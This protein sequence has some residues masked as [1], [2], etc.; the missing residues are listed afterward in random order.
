MSEPWVC[1]EDA[2]LLAV[3][4]P[5]GVTT[6]RADDR[7][8]DGMFDWVRRLRPDVRLSILHRLDKATSGVLLFGKSPEA[9][10]ALS[11]QFEERR[12][13][14][15]YELLVARDDRRPAEL[16]CDDPVDSGGTA[17]SAT[18]DFRLAG[19]GPAVQRFDAHPH[20]GRT[21]QVRVHA[22]SLGM[23][24]LG[25]ADHGGAPGPRLCLHAAGLGI[26]HPDGRSL[27][28]SAARPPSFD[29]LLAG[30]EPSAAQLAAR[31]AVEARS[32]LFDPIDTD[33][34]LCIDR[35]H[36]GFPD[37]RVERLG[38]VAFVVDHRDDASPLP[39]PWI[40][41]WSEALD[42][43]AVYVQRRPGNGEDARLV[44]GSPH[45]QIEVRELGLRYL[46]DLR[47]SATSTGL[48]LDQRETRRE[49]LAAPLAGASVLNVFAH[50]G[51]LS[52][53]AAVAGATTVS[54]D[55]S[56]RYLQWA[57]DNLRLN[58]LDPDEH[59]TIY[60][61]ALDWMGRLAKKGRTFDVVL[62][63][64]PSTSTTRRG[65]QRWSVARDLHALVAQAARLC[66]PG[67]R[68]YVSTNMRRLGWARF[69][70]QIDQGVSAAGRAAAVD[71][72]TL[73]LDHRSGS[74]DPPYLK[75]AWI[76]LDH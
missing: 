18:T 39:T 38:A 73:P 32:I 70:D 46:V 67:G 12:V 50:T 20:S 15:R 16:T 9:N 42:A 57:K 53:A 49:L 3:H 74:G 71:I 43:Q 30:D 69:L 64:P 45:D 19:S 31:V 40:D 33:A 36:D 2:H 35:H 65:S 27:D 29:A 51:S 75:A 1:F 8:Q 47:A 10:R 13:R 63:D 48:F 34:H 37:V 23:P 55:L 7:A 17:R 61:D 44:R 24:I 52:V 6:H 66:A 41:A 21:H 14:K 25:D 68:V 11:A 76:A 4:K 26:E 62:V 54:I 58:G 59:D 28:M 22:T 56:Q 72:R 5:A 60:G